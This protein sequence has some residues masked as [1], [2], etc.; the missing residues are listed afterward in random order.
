MD[1]F[2]DVVQTVSRLASLQ[3][4]TFL[5]QRREEAEEVFCGFES[6]REFFHYLEQVH[7]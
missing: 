1:S 4:D 7:G 6:P 2:E 5:L 3:P